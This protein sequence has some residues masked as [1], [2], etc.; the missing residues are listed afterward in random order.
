M[1][2]EF[3]YEFMYMQNIVKS[4]LKSGVS[5]GLPSFQMLR[6]GGRLLRLAPA[7]PRCAESQAS[8]ACKS[9]TGPQGP[10]FRRLTGFRLLPVTVRHWQLEFQFQCARK[11]SAVTLQRANSEDE[12]E[13]YTC[14]SESS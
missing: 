3:K 10:G 2:Y 1:T 9:S 6:P 14:V 12:S 8:G 5:T 7:V 11:P 13:P 4:Y